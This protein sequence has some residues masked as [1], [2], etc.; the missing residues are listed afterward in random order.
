MEALAAIGLVGNIVQFVDFSG[1][2]IAK[3]VQLYHSYDG[4]L[5][6]NVDI[7]V[8]TKHLVVLIKKLEDDAIRV[9]DGALRTS[10]RVGR[11]M[12]RSRRR[13]ELSAHG[14]SEKPAGLLR[15]TAVAERFDDASHCD[16]L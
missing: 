9:G 11:R 6:E 3:S 1:E 16:C 7:E 5:P 8:V 12:Y 15:I 2:L 4:A 14:S 13:S 10:R